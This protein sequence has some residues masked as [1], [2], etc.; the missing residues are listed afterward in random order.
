VTAAPSRAQAMLKALF[1][2]V[3]YA[4]LALGLTGTLGMILPAGL[5]WSGAAL[6]VGAGVAGW[7]LLAYEGRPAAALGLALDRRAPAEV[8]GGW[9]LGVGVAGLVVAGIAALG[10]LYWVAA[11]GGVMP[12]VL[13][14][15]G[16]LLALALPAAAEE[17]AVRG[18]LLQALARGFG[19]V[20]ALVGTS[21]LFAA[22]HL[23]NPEVGAVGVA[24]IAAAGLALG[25][26]VVRTRCLWWAIGAH[27]GWNWALAWPADLPVSGLDLADTP[28]LDARMVG[29]SWLDGGAFGPEASAVTVVVL[30]AGAAVLWRGRWPRPASGRPAPLYEQA[31]SERPE[32]KDHEVWTSNA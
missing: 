20:P 12:F 11:E 10:G 22:L 13:G 17:V 27:L 9:L 29:S 7:L 14:G 25:V 3:V 21:V 2:V 6:L 19:V 1:D 23:R 28:G 24:G 5:A 30:L 16:L 18:Y 31:E 32:S 4:L 8:S 26:L 15:A